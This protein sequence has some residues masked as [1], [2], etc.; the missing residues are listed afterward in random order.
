MLPW[1][2]IVVP[3]DLGDLSETSLSAAVDLASKFG[4]QLWVLNVLEPN[5]L[6]TYYSQ[7]AGGLLGPADYDIKLRNSRH[8][9]LSHFVER[10]VPHTLPTQILVRQGIA[11][12]EIQKVV[13][14]AKADLL[15]LATHGKSSWLRTF[16][17]TVPQK[18]I[19]MASCPVL[20]LHPDKSPA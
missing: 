20:V 6:D 3:I 17:Q 9:E 7:P 10:L 12:E 2:N 4:S 5:P 11:V 8:R 18:E 14:E 13:D 15:I 1:K 16:H 19:K